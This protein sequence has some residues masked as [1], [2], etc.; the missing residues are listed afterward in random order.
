MMA[1]QRNNSE[2]KCDLNPIAPYLDLPLIAI[3]ESQ[4]GYAGSGTVTGSGDVVYN[5]DG[6]TTVSGTKLFT[7][8]VIGPG[9][10]ISNMVQFDAIS[11]LRPAADLSGGIKCRIHGGRVVLSV[12]SYDGSS[13]TEKGNLLYRLGTTATNTSDFAGV[14]ENIPSPAGSG[15]IASDQIKVLLSGAQTWLVDRSR[16]VSFTGLDLFTTTMA[17]ING[18]AEPVQNPLND[19]LR[20]NNY[21][22]LQPVIVEVEVTDATVM[23]R[24][25]KFPGLTGEFDLADYFDP[26]RMLKVVFK[27]NDGPAWTYSAADSDPPVQSLVL[28]DSIH[29]E[30][31]YR[32]KQPPRIEG[33]PAVWIARFAGDVM[34]YCSPNVS[35]GEFQPWIGYDS[36][37][38]H[39][40]IRNYKGDPLFE[41]KVPGWTTDGN[42]TWRWSWTAQRRMEHR[43]DTYEAEYTWPKYKVLKDG[44]IQ[45]NNQREGL[46]LQFLNYWQRGG[47]N[48]DFREYAGAGKYMM[49]FDDDELLYLNSRYHDA[50]KHPPLEGEGIVKLDIMPSRSM[51]EGA[52]QIYD[53]A[54]GYPAQGFP[55][56]MVIS[57]YRKNR[58]W[59]VNGNGNYYQ[60][61]DGY[62]IQD[63][64]T[65][66]EYPDGTGA[67]NKAAPGKITVRAGNRVVTIPVNVR[68]PLRE[69]RGFYGNLEGNRWPAYYETDIPYT[70]TGLRNLDTAV[71]DRFSIE[72]QGSDAFG[73]VYTRTKYLK[74]LS[75]REKAAIA[76]TGRWTALFDNFHPTYACVTAYYQRTAES[77][78]VMI[79]GKELKSIF[80]LFIGEK[81]LEGK[82]MGAKIWLNDYRETPTAE[83]NVP[84]EF[85]NVTKYMSPFIR[86]YVFPVHTTTTFESWDGDPHLFHDS[87]TEWFLSG[88]TLAKRIPDSY[89]DGTHANAEKPYLRYYIN[90]VEQTAGRS[91]KEFTH[92]WDTPGEYTLKAEYRTNGDLT[93]RSHKIIIV[94]Y[95]SSC[96]GK[97]IGRIA[98][99]DLS[100][101]EVRWLGISDPSIYKVAEVVDVYSLH[102][103]R[104]GPRANTPFIN[105]WAEHNDYAA[106]Y[107][108][109]RANAP[110]VKDFLAR[111]DNLDWFWPF[112]ALHYSSNWRDNLPYGLPVYVPDSRVT[113]VFSHELDHFSGTLGGL[114]E[115]VKQ[116][117][118]QYIVPL[119]SHTDYQ[120]NRMRTNPSCLYDLAAIWSNARGAFSGKAVLPDDPNHI[121]APDITDEQKDRQEFYYA[122]KSGRMAVFSFTGP[123]PAHVTVRNVYGGQDIFIAEGIIR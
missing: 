27:V 42:G 67:G 15:M 55:L 97:Q 35:P 105:R 96:S 39:L 80:L 50:V 109:S 25:L 117:K 72:Y 22:L 59:V 116:T 93:T 29:L 64:G 6:S 101:Q 43:V 91:G 49:G 89:L 51:P 34:Y 1:K 73:N 119:I 68:S 66:E 5:A 60:R 70:L 19:S 45:R 108:W 33:I 100:A 47:D 87:G 44:G 95:P 3:P 46:N 11:L 56:N 114:F 65:T 10:D 81:N 32:G 30:V 2:N 115:S 118:W 52:D 98:F 102:Q 63:L 104:D 26:E 9:E 82:G 16:C 83:Y 38:H 54:T 21:A 57:A 103:Y 120:G 18:Q 28:G 84:R 37:V 94:D 79:A 90:G 74:D 78:R 85:G 23:S 53:V 4:P 20:G 48:S 61:Y 69:E 13:A 123:E 31:L 86:T 7:S 110:F 24:G 75:G 71:L 121:L 12:Y 106:Q 62:E 111:Y 41:E 122:L 76:S 17:Y 112:R 40:Q 14:P 107:V 88:R 113:R 99:R 92:T 8:H 77:G 36:Q 58:E